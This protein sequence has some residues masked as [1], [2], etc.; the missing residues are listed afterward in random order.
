MLQ[1]CSNSFQ[2][3]AIELIASA[4]LLITAGMAL[5]ELRRRRLI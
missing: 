1:R 3:V 4:G 2:Y 5:A